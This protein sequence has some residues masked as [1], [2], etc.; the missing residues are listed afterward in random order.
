MIEAWYG[1]YPN[2]RELL[3][4]LEPQHADSLSAVYAIGPSIDGRYA[5]SWSR[6]H[7]HVVNGAYVFDEKGMNGLRFE[8]REDGGM[9]ETWTARDGDGTLTAIL[10]RINVR[11]LVRAD[12]G[13]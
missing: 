7:G 3:L 2:G 8:P 5:A 12:A 13:K 11:N 10:R 1:F 6:R 4:A 9:T